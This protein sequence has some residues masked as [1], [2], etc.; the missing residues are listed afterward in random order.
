MQASV[1]CT[2]YVTGYILTEYSVINYILCIFSFQKVKHEC[3]LL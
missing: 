3:K 2:Q 1:E